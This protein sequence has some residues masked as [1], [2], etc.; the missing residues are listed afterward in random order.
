MKRALLLV[1]LAAFASVALSSPI[2][3]TKRLKMRVAV[4]PLDWSDHDSIDNWQIPVEYRNAIYEKLT[5]KL[6]D[7]GKFIV[8]E[9]EAMEALLN[10]KAIKTE[11]SGQSQKGKITP[12]QSLVKGKVTDFELASKGGGGGIS[13]GGLSLGGRVSE[14]KVGIN[15]RIFDVDTSELLASEDAAKSTQSHSFSV[16]GGL[17]SV[18]GSFDAFDRSPLGEATTKCISDAVD[19]II[20][21]LDKQPWSSKVADWDA[22]AKEVT[23]GAGAEQGV[24]VG[25]TFD[26]YRV[27]KI[28][29]DPETGEILGKKTSRVGS[30]RVTTVDKRFSVA[31][32]VDGTDFMAGDIVK[33]VLT[34]S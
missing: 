32:P 12:A 23:I 26:V 3:Q 15:V 20:I 10:E 31:V 29:K 19:K 4:A 21:I 11:T 14:A 8:L 13:I 25:D 1:A 5:K 24:Q 34:R 6:M 16:A 27:T 9:R 18:F 17:N 33:E 22:Q 30:V 2:D 28:I 7:S